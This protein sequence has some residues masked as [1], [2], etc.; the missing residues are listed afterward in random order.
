MQ[1]TLTIINSITFMNFCRGGLK[2]V[3]RNKTIRMKKNYVR[4]AMTMDKVV[5]KLLWRNIEI[6]I[7]IDTYT[8]KH[9]SSSRLNC[10][11][12]DER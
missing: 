4:N 6:V 9:R 7:L 8:R 1:V 2:K 12:N 5:K 3:N 11:I 10:I